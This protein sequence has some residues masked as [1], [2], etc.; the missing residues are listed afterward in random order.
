MLCCASARYASFSCITVTYNN[1]LSWRQSRAVWCLPL[2]LETARD[3]R[4]GAWNTK[5]AKRVEARG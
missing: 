4:S 5:Y 3:L 1:E 2:L